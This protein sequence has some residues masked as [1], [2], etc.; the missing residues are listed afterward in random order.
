MALRLSLSYSTS[1]HVFIDFEKAF[2][3]VQHSWI[4][5]C[6]KGFGFPEL[7]IQWI[8]QIQ[9]FNTASFYF[10]CVE[11]GLI[12]IESGTRQGD[13]VSGNLFIIAIE[14]LA[15][16]IRSHP[17]ILPAHLSATA[18]KVIGLH[19]DDIWFNTHDT[20]SMVIAINLCESYCKASGSIIN[21]KKSYALNQL[22][23]DLF[24]LTQIPD[25]GFSH[26]GLPINK[27]GYSFPE[28]SILPKVQKTTQ[29]LKNL[30]LSTN[31][32]KL[33][34]HCYLF[35]L[36]TYA[37]Y[38]LEPSTAFFTLFSKS[39]KHLLWN[40]RPK[41]ATKRL[42]QTTENTGI[43]LKDPKTLMKA[44]HSSFMFRILSSESP[45]SL[46][47]SEHYNSLQKTLKLTQQTLY[48]RNLC[49]G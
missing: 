14:P 33:L 21:K 39:I 35:S 30:H 45:V 37:A 36:F 41:I 47:I 9:D 5:K 44:L 4:R 23:D 2:D 26:L 46:A 1:T 40:K 8:Q 34:A 27:W 15:I 3:K 42:V 38:V 12:N 6:L 7:F 17:Q 32:F 48:S 19:V 13:P 49:P 31:G 22:T 11:H 16:Q 28:N 18:T 29:H 20:P 43:G 25:Q 24:G 10:N